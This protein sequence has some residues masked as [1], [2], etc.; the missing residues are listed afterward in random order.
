MVK[1][2]VFL[3]KVFRRPG[4]GG[5]ESAEAYSE[6]EYQWGRSLVEEY[7]EPARDLGRK[8]V[9]DIGCG[10]GGKTVAYGEA[11]AAE[12]YGADLAVEHA[13]ASQAFARRKTLKAPDTARR[14]TN[15]APDSDEKWFRWGF[16]VA[17][18]ARL[19]FSDESFD[20]VVA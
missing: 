19:P 15:K 4:V 12:V 8:R 1:L 17:D 11:G 18:A 5:R 2:I 14:K 9:L 7:L 13:Q 16:T 6:W 20:T 3:N 10:L